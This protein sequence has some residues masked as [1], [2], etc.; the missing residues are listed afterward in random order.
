MRWIRASKAITLTIGAMDDIRIGTAFRAV[1]IRKGWRQSD[2][3]KRAAVSRD[4]VSR[5]ERG[6]AGQV[7]LSVVRGVAEVLGIRM[8]VVLRWQGS[9]LDRV[10]NAG[11][12]SMHEGAAELFRALPEWVTAPEVSFSIYG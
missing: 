5:I 9:E 8:D 6:G 1:R 4:M 3:A 11:H 12:A 10:I 7:P 2:V